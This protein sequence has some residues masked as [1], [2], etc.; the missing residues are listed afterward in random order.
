[1]MRERGGREEDARRRVREEVEVE[2]A[3]GPK[4][5]GERQGAATRV[6]SLEL[7]GVRIEI[8]TE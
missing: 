2:E 4:C 5:G 6:R 1:M 7:L 8:K 3:D